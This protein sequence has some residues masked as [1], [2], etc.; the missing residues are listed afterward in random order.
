MA[1]LFMDSFDNYSSA[2]L[3]RKYSSGATSGF[4]TGRFG[5]AA[6][7]GG[8]GGN[9]TRIL[10]A[11]KT[12]LIVGFNFNAAA[13][14]PSGT[15]VMMQAIDGATEQWS[16]R[17]TTAGFFTFCRNGT[18]LATSTAVPTFGAWNHLEVKVTIDDTVGAYEL[19]LNGTNILSATGVDTKQTANTTADRVNVGSFSQA[20]G[21]TCAIDDYYILDTSGAANNNFL[22]DVKCISVL[23]SANGAN[24]GL[25]TS[26]GTNHAALVD[27]NP[28][29][30]DTDYNESA[31]VGVKD[32]Y[33]MAALTGSWAS[34]NGVQVNM[35]ARKDDAGAR[36]L[37]SV[38]RSAGSD[39]DGAAQ[40]IS[41]T[42]FL[43]YR[44]IA[45]LDP[46][47]AAAWANAAAVDAAEFGM[48]VQ[49]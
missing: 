10:P 30:D 20:G 14:T 29:N 42:S 40:T 44:E 31:S 49:A 18:V 5:S 41:S 45:E 32:T 13:A 16:V 2:Q 26:T 8:N 17:M 7:I 12:T 38:I 21:T 35:V 6:P 37:C 9:F 46:G 48:K 33:D 4:V 34:I 23:P 25:T 43:T 47:T 36:S 19:R 27:E 22:G 3:L 24:T 11:A 39:F 15:C 28:A 1:I